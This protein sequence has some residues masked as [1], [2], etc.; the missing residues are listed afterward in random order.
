MRV[1]LIHCPHCGGEIGM[2]D[3]AFNRNISCKYCGSTLRVSDR[4]ESAECR[5]KAAL[6]RE[7]AEKIFS[8]WCGGGDIPSD[9]GKRSR[10]LNT[11]LY[12]IP[13]YRIDAGVVQ[14]RNGIT[15]TGKF[16]A[17][18][19][20]NR[21]G[22]ASPLKGIN[23]KIPDLPSSSFL[24][25]PPPEDCVV[26]LP[27]DPPPDPAAYT[28]ANML[29]PA[30]AEYLSSFA[31][32]LRVIFYPVLITAYAYDGAEYELVIDAFTGETI[33]FTAPPS[34][35]RRSFLAAFTA[36]GVGF[37]AGF[38]FKLIRAVFSGTP[39]QLPLFAASL[40]FLTIFLIWLLK[41][42]PPFLSAYIC[43]GKTQIH[44]GKEFD[45]LE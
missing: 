38:A 35:A 4:E 41:R 24:P 40:L 17:H 21:F 7:S 19:P 3:Y 1:S 5:I 39:A 25:P 20:A 45:G 13:F 42:L 23:V 32:R 26:I 12:N 37:T 27:S 10:I 33:R 2:T 36:S 9:L 8:I 43:S 11:T 31:H 15:V 16:T 29:R 22:P 44:D 34:P 14:V 6:S 28:R 18:L 30:G